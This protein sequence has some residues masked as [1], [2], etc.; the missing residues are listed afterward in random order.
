MPGGSTSLRLRSAQDSI[1]A[2]T[3]DGEVGYAKS[4]HHK[5]PMGGDMK[6]RINQTLRD[7]IR[8]QVLGCILRWRT[9]SG[10]L[11]PKSPD[12]GFQANPPSLGAMA[13]SK[14]DRL[15]E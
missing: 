2:R 6:A 14:L 12:C 13:L 10:D 1:V 5:L 15:N 3:K 4:H 11:A 9:G 7:A 8:Y